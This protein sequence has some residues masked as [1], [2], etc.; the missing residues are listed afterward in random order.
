VVAA[1]RDAAHVAWAWRWGETLRWSDDGEPGGTA[2]RPMLEVLTKRDLDR[3]V[4]LVARVFGGVKLG[5]GGLARAYG[6]AV[7]R[8]LDAARVVEVPDRR[9]F[10][11]RAGF[12]DVDVLLRLLDDESV[13]H[14]PVTFGP[15]ASRCRASSWPRRGRRWRRAPSRP[16]G[17]GRSGAGRR[18]PP[19]TRRRHLSGS[20]C[21]SL[22]GTAPGT[23]PSP[24]ACS[25]AR[26]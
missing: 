26:R 19:P 6:G 16:P 22:P 9:A 8:A 23:S 1:E 12:A 20:S 11:V 5:A 7:A 2:G 3:T 24:R 15:T 17:A 18:R 21:G 25:T 13:D 4:A 10:A 14:A